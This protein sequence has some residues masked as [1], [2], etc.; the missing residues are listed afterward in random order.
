MGPRL[1]AYS[2]RPALLNTIYLVIL[3]SSC[4]VAVE[5]LADFVVTDNIW[6]W[7]A[8]HDNQGPVTDGKHPSKHGLV[9]PWP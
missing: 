9:R 3:S 6:L 5:V 7:R 1:F 4:Q 8:D 2:Q